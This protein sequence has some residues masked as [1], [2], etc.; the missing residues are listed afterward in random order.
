MTNVKKRESCCL[1]INEYWRIPEND[2]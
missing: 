2:I 1:E